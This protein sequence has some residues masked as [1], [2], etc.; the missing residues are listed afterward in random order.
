[1]I[2]CTGNAMSGSALPG[3]DDDSAVSVSLRIG[4]HEARVDDV[5]TL[6]ESH[7]GKSYH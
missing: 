1:M 2:L 5:A 7:S 4:R 3:P 6:K